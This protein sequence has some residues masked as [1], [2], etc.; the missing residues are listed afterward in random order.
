MSV[1]V[2][3]IRHHGPGCARCLVGALTA[4]EPNVILI[5]GPP[6]AEAVLPLA[7]HPDMKPP[8]ALLVYPVEAFTSA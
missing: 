6:D 8:V 1:H 5:E 4:L 3:G 2:F 7:G